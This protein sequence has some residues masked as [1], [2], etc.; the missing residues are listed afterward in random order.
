MTKLYTF[1]STRTSPE[2]KP[3]KLKTTELSWGSLTD[4]CAVTP[5]RL[6]HLTFFSAVMSR[7]QTCG[8]AGTW[9]PERNKE[10][11][12][13]GFFKQQFWLIVA[14]S[15]QDS[16]VVFAHQVQYAPRRSKYCW[17]I[18]SNV[19]DKNELHAVPASAVAGGRGPAWQ[20]VGALSNPVSLKAQR[21]KM[22]LALTFFFFVWCDKWQK[23]NSFAG[24]HS[25]K[26]II[27]R[28]RAGPLDRRRP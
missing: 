13:W 3:E 26:N 17:G 21:A 9:K 23:G 14:K 28:W 15:Q 2:R 20:L 22:M 10:C 7:Q 6:L 19:S 16:N 24:C 11:F 12:F 27:F 8:Q 25:L 4:R 5:S 1:L 18:K